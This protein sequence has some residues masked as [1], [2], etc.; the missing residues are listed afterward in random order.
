[1]NHLNRL[2]LAFFLA[3]FV[4]PL[5]AQFE[6]AEVLGTIRDPAGNSVLKA[7]VTLLN[8]ATGIEAKTITNE[9]GAYDFLNVKAGMYTVSVEATGFSK[10]S[11]SDVSVVVNARQRVDFTLQVGAVT[12]SI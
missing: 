12:E 5:T 2:F 4:A 3:T 10:V 7:A 9:T 11:T 1:M 6:Y 8:Q